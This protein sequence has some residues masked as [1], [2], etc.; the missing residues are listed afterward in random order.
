M[1]HEPFLKGEPVTFGELFPTVKSFNLKGKEH[2]DFSNVAG[3]PMERRRTIHY[4]ASSM[5]AKIR[6]S[7]PRCQQGGY[8]LQWTIDA[9]VRGKETYYEK[10]FHC[11][12]H[13]GTP[14]GR[15]RGESCCNYIDIEIDIEYNK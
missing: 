11:G 8:E 14:K 10:T 13:E 9:I 6:C 3:I 2:G 12:G 4:T 1:A 7:N 15:P 5:P